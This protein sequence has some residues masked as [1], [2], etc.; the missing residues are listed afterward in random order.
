MPQQD[1]VLGQMEP[2]APIEWLERRRLRAD[3]AASLGVS[4]PPAQP[5]PLRRW[6]VEISGQPAAT[7]FARSP[8]EASAARQEALGIVAPAESVRVTR[9]PAFAPVFGE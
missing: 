6:L 1:F 8:E 7:V 9:I 5:L 3:A 2:N 4:P